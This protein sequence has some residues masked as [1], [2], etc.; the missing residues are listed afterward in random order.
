MIRN[1][2]ICDKIETSPESFVDKMF[3]WWKTAEY[4]LIK[5]QAAAI[6]VACFAPSKSR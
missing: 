3:P 1:R 4:C 2:H 5:P 6:L